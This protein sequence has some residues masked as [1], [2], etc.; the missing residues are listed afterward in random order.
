MLK[1]AACENAA[2][3]DDIYRAYTEPKKR[4]NQPKHLHPHAAFGAIFTANFITGFFGMNTN[5]MFLG[6]FQNGTTIV[7]GSMLALFAILAG[8]FCFLGKRRE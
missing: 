8:L 4:Q 3:I 1:N 2:R 6:G 5:G 7:A